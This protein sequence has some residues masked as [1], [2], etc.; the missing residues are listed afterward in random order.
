MVEI[1]WRSENDKQGIDHNAALSPDAAA[2]LL[3]ARTAKPTECEWVLPSPTDSTK[4]VSRHTLK[5]WWLKAEKSAGLQHVKQKAWHST[6]RDWASEMEPN[7]GLGTIQARGG[8]KSAQT[9]LRCYI[10]PD[11]NKMREAFDKRTRLRKL[12]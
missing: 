3:E 8:W 7:S 12:A 6:R 1:H 10:H 4:P 5:N 9:L 2:A 11:A